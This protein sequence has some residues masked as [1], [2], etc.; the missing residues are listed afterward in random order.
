MIPF[1]KQVILMSFSCDHCGF[2]NNEIQP[3]GEIQEKGIRLTLKV[4]SMKDLNRR[5]V[6][7]DFSKVRLDELD[8]EIPPQTQKGEV[9]TVEGIFERSITGL[10]QDQDRRRVDNPEAAKTIDD[11]VIALKK[12]RTMETPFTLIIEDISGNSAIENLEAPHPDPGCTT[13][14]FNR[15]VEQDH[16]LGIFTNAELN[17]VEKPEKVEKPKKVGILE[18]VEEGEWTLEE[19]HGEVLRFPTNCPECLSP[20]ETNMKVTSIP[21]FKDVVIMATNCDACGAKTNEVKSGG[22]INDLGTKIEV[23]VAGKEDFSRDVLK[24][25]ACSLRIVE[26]DCEVGSNALGGRFTT[27]E[28]ILSAMKTQ[29]LEMGGMFQD[30]EDIITKKKM[31]VFIA[32]LDEVLE[33]KRK[34]TLVLDDPSG[35]SYVQSLRDDGENDERLKITKYTRNFDQMEELGLNDMVTENY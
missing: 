18:K 7:S 31:S 33:G 11:F 34:V 4:T 23:T 10:E 27:V 28:G 17:E 25:D 26:L 15:T 5:I 19:L 1:Y 24:S 35:N 13:K 30:S 3:G 14:W 16:L 21:H 20:A 6:K 29:L 9:T 8:F 22:G 12:L 32:E 2:E